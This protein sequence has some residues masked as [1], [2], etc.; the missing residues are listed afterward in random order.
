MAG[1]SYS[2]TDQPLSLQ[3][4]MYTSQL[5]AVVMLLDCVLTQHATQVLSNTV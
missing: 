1:Q 5:V 3:W 4:S 2:M